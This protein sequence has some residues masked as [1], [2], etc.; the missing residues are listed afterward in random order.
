MIRFDW[1]GLDFDG[2]LSEHVADAATAQIHP[3]SLAALQRI[4]SSGRIALA[5]ISGR[6]LADLQPRVPVPG[7]AF[8]GNHGLE[9]AHAGWHW[10]DPLA[11]AAERDLAAV[12]ECIAPHLGRVAGS[13]QDIK[14]YSISVDWRQVPGSDWAALPEIVAGLVAEFPALEW[15]RGAYGL[16]IRPRGAGTKGTAAAMLW[17]RQKGHGARPAF[18]GDDRTDEDA[19]AAAIAAGG[20]GAKVGTGPSVAQYRFA[21]PAAVADWLE[22]LAEK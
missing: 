13:F 11:L 16:D 10:Q 17:Q 2:T 9:I 12:A 20:L 7:I 19:F 14:R 21:H 15:Q 3:R 8:A 6:A 22:G 18:V 5:V 1:L 4:A